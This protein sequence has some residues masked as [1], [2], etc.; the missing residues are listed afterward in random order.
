[1]ST[2]TIKPPPGPGRLTGRLHHGEN[3]RQKKNANVI[4]NK[5]NIGTLMKD[6]QAQL[7]ESEARQQRDREESEARHQDELAKIRIEYEE[8]EARICFGT[9]GK[10]NMD[11]HY[12]TE[13]VLS[14]PTKRCIYW[15]LGCQISATPLISPLGRKFALTLPLLDKRHSTLGASLFKRSSRVH[16]AFFTSKF[17]G[18]LDH[19]VGVLTCVSYCSYYWI[20]ILLL[21][22]TLV[23]IKSENVDED[24]L[25]SSNNLL[26]ISVFDKGG[27]VQ[28]ASVS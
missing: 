12:G 8:S 17:Q 14:V 10:G 21:Y 16:Q 22:S 13:G 27:V 26:T 7:D 24:L 18:S 20:K 4:N 9:D 6:L 1:M 23:V 5:A 11:K 2:I 3:R 15:T 25:M 28:A 19:K